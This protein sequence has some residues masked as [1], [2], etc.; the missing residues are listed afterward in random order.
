MPHGEAAGILREQRDGILVSELRP[1]QIELEIHE[2]GIDF[3][4]QHV[5]AGRPLEGRELVGV[6]VIRE[7]EPRV[8]AHPAPRV[9]LRDALSPAGQPFASP[10][11]RREGDVL[12]ADRPGRA[13]LRR[14]VLAHELRADVR[15]ARHG[16]DAVEER[17]HLLRRAVVVPRELEV[18][19]ADLRDLLDG[20]VEV[21]RE[22][23]A[24]GV[25]LEPD[26][27]RVRA[28]AVPRGGAARGRT[29]ARG[30]HA[31]A[32]AHRGQLEQE[33][34][35]A[36]LSLL[37]V[38]GHGVSPFSMVTAGSRHAPTSACSDCRR[39]ACRCTGSRAASG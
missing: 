27:V 38:L 33:R 34:P 22:L 14:G 12:L 32:H 26:H 31:R 35:A 25:H 20:G 9:E 29:G 36:H 15:A 3:L 23:I 28:G 21:L 6:V 17:A 30:E 11:V 24:H 39:R 10:V 4:D 18:P 2:R 19:V 13:D 5:V 8:A 16:A 1:V 7:L 37:V